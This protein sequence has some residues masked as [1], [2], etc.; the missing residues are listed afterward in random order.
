[1]DNFDLRKFV[2]EK[3]L[4]NENAPGYDT[5]KFGESLPTMESVKA[6]YEAKNDIKE[7]V[8]KVKELADKV[9]TVASE[10][11]K[12]LN[13]SE[14]MEFRALIAQ[15]F[16]MID[17]AKKDDITET[18][19]LGVKEK[20]DNILYVMDPVQVIDNLLLAM[21]TDDANLYLDA[22]IQDH[23][24]MMVDEA[25]KVEEVSSRE[26]SRIEGLLNQQLKSKLLNYFEEL[27]YDLVEEEVFPVEDVIDHLSMEMTKRIYGK[28]L[29]DMTIDEEDS[30]KKP[31]PKPVAKDLK[32]MKTN[33]SD[34]K[35]RLKLEE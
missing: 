34:L 25:K 19:D 10:G 35:K 16:D 8:S 33:F 1:M 24:I 12:D 15:S 22:I 23:E 2:S 3:T 26:G 4:L 28:P 13:G 27:F 5:R 20:M 31:L 14:L 17:E 11:I 29:M 7:D 9:L 21:S 18:R 30:K 6:A 32:K